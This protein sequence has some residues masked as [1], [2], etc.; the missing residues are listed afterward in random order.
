MKKIY[1]AIFLAFII[2]VSCKKDKVIDDTIFLPT[3]MLF[4]DL[5]VGRFSHVIPTADF[6]WDS[7][8]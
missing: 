6:N 2:G 7:N 3:D 5:E 8:I 4:E 1:I